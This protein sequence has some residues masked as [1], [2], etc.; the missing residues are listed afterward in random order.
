MSGLTLP[1][2]IM[3]GYLRFLPFTREKEFARSNNR[4]KK[5]EELL[6]NRII[7]AC[8]IFN[9]T[10][11]TENRFEMKSR[12]ESTLSGITGLVK[13]YFDFK[14]TNYNQATKRLL[15][16]FQ[17]LLIFATPVY[18]MAVSFERPLGFKLIYPFILVICFCGLHF[19]LSEWLVRG[20]GFGRDFSTLS[21]KKIWQIAI[22]GYLLG[23]VPYRIAEYD[24]VPYYYKNASLDQVDGALSSFLRMLLIWCLSVFIVTWFQYRKRQNSF[25]STRNPANELPIFGLISAPVIH[26]GSISHVT[27]EEHYSRVFYKEKGALKNHQ[28]RSSLQEVLNHLP[29]ELFIRIHRSHIVNLDKIEELKSTRQSYEIILENGEYNLPVSR[30]RNAEIFPKIKRYRAQNSTCQMILPKSLNR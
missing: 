20:L 3:N 24:L 25:V 22:V 8:S 16:H 26:S 13:S 12:H 21:I 7:G 18:L 23:Y 11:N 29:H 5:K 17:I 6:Q 27:V 4:S 19:L 28:I 10:F 2:R 1:F 15:I 30:H 14:I 9:I